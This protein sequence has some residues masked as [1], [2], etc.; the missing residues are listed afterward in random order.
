M[1]K[2]QVRGLAHEQCLSGSFQLGFISLNLFFQGPI[3]LTGAS[4]GDQ[5]DLKKSVG[6]F[7]QP[8]TV[9]LI[10]QRRCMSLDQR[11]CRPRQQSGSGVSEGQLQSA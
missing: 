8:V 3:L 11:N 10:D 5:T 4:P 6:L 1:V 7:Y 9:H 2:L